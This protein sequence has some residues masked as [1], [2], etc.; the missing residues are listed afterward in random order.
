M[1]DATLTSTARQSLFPIPF[2]LLLLS[3]L[4]ARVD[5][6]AI[7]I[8]PPVSTSYLTWKNAPS[9]NNPPATFFLFDSPLCPAQQ[10]QQQLDRIQQVKLGNDEDE[11]EEE[12]V[13]RGGERK[14]MIVLTFEE[15]GQVDFDDVEIGLGIKLEL[16]REEVGRNDVVRALR[17]QVECETIVLLL[18]ELT[19]LEDLLGMCLLSSLCCFVGQLY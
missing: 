8:I 16:P 4:V 14:T 12:Q 15:I 10:R 2:L 17:R 11:I 7:P 6:A 18:V 3:L 9:S 13:E 5:S 19:S 1:K